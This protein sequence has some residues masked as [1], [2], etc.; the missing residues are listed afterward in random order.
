[1]GETEA[2]IFLLT[3]VLSNAD[4]VAVRHHSDPSLLIDLFLL[5][6]SVSA[7]IFLTESVRYS[8]LDST[9]TSYSLAW[10]SYQRLASL[11]ELSTESPMICSIEPLKGF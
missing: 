11:G 9:K 8:R 7:T 6:R 2:S 1:M 10:Y 4:F 5:Q 3:F